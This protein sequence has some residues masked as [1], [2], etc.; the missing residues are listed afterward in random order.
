[1]T[2]GVRHPPK[3][4]ESTEGRTIFGPSR[5]PSYKGKPFPLTD[6]RMVNCWGWHGSLME[7]ILSFVLH[8]GMMA[9][10]KHSGKILL[11]TFRPIG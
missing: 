3:G 5:L 2:G 6:H 8:G 9:T 10:M 4:P 11:N 1:M 7:S